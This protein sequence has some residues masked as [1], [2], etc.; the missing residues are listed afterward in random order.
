MVMF[1]VY[2]KLIIF[3]VLFVDWKL[4][5][6]YLFCYWLSFDKYIEIVK[7]GFIGF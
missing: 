6:L 7:L 2:R 1:V 5:K 3:I 4:C